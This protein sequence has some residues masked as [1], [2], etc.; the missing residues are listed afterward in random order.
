M[1]LPWINQS[2]RMGCLASPAVQYIKIGIGFTKYPNQIPETTRKQ[3]ETG[4]GRENHATRL[5]DDGFLCKS[6]V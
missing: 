4:G 6:K 3:T 5:F 1:K 2:L